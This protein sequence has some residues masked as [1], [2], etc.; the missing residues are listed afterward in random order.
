MPGYETGA[1]ITVDWRNQQIEV[2]TVDHELPDASAVDDRNKLVKAGMN[3]QLAS[4]PEDAWHAVARA[5][6]TPAT[7]ALQLREAHDAN[8][9]L[10]LEE[11][12]DGATLRSVHSRVW[13]SELF[14]AIQPRTGQ[15]L[16][17]VDD[18]Q[19]LGMAEDDN[20]QAI[21]RYRY[22]S[23][24]H[25][26]RHVR[27]TI[28]ATLY[29][30][31]YEESILSRRVTRALIA[32]PIIY[33]FDDGTESVFG[34]VVRDGITRLASAWKVLAG[35]DSDPEEA[36]NLAVNTLLAQYQ[37]S[38]SEPA[39][40]LTQRMA[41]GR[42]NRRKQ[43]REEF[44]KEIANAGEGNP[45]S[46]RAIQIAQSYQVPSHVTVGVQAHE[47]TALPVEDVFDDALRS[48]L[49]SVHVEFKP[50]D[51]AAQNVE[52]AARAL[53]R[54]LHGSTG[55][56]VEDGLHAVYELAVGLRRASDTP[57]VY[58]NHDIPGN[59]LWRAVQLLHTLT[60]PATFEELRS[61]A[62]EIKG[63][64]RMTDK[65]YAGL[66]GPIVDHPWR[67]SKKSAAQ[68]ARNAWSNGGV[69]FK[70]VLADGWAPMV[71]NDFTT[72]IKPALE[73]S[74]EA[75]LTLALAGGTALIADKLLTRNVGS[76]VS[77]TR[78][79]GKVP[80]RADVHKI[81]EGLAR[82]GNELGLW[83]LALAAQ[84]FEDGRLPRNSGTRQQLGLPND[85]ALEGDDEYQHLVV[86]LN[87]PDHIL[88]DN[89]KPVLLLEWDVA[90]ASDP[91]RARQ[92]LEP[93]ES[94]GEDGRVDEDTD[95]NGG[96]DA[97]KPSTIGNDDGRQEDP[98]D[99]VAD[100][101]M[102]VEQQIQ[103]GRRVLTNCLADAKTSVDEL[104]KLGQAV[105]YPPLFGP[106]EAWND[107]RDTALHVLNTL[108]NHEGDYVTDRAEEY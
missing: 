93:A 92:V 67:S 107:L 12:V 57:N 64:R 85:Q 61:R 63:D 59:G 83:T 36:A 75:R 42:Q 20:P 77:R 108:Q 24:N 3:A 11:H 91:E 2:S 9:S 76:S 82:K 28:T 33:D 105:T 51:T 74:R 70:E 32:H 100:T 41:L 53:K 86:D 6:V 103:E 50:W 1:P 84:R 72:L 8:A 25:L 71:T 15:E 43:L 96:S 29:R 46:L 68:Q 101:E 4:L 60:R 87:A 49:A 45:P 55:S 30:N 34:L 27:Q 73:G 39:K 23:V 5:A 21:L 94:D 35:P 95:A 48:I 78:A 106:A 99:A 54:V 18:P 65:G 19:V 104:E 13:L 40:P 102:P 98:S 47:R 31:S 81:V 66:L 69:L 52:V 22:E 80:F 88:R 10:L 37:I 79:P 17:A 7:V 16:L 62:K 97:F 44:N 58:G 26:K 14:P 89:G 90:V 56:T 38:A